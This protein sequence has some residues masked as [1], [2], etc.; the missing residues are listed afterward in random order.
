MRNGNGTGS[1][2]RIGGSESRLELVR[3]ALHLVHCPRGVSCT[4][5]D[6]GLL[7]LLVVVREARECDERGRAANEV[8]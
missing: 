7:V 1:G 5:D 3:A 6:R 4:F 8:C 2:S